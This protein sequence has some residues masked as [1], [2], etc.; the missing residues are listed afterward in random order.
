MLQDTRTIRAAHVHQQYRPDIDGLRTIAVMIVVLAHAGFTG[1]SG[2]FIGVDVFFVISGFVVTNSILGDLS[3]G[4]FSFKA[5]YARRASRLAPAL[6]LMLIATFCFSILFVFPEDTFKLAKNILA[7]ATMTSNIYLSKQTGYFDGRAADHPLLHTWSLSVEEQ[8]YLVLPVVLVLLRRRSRATLIGVL[9]AVTLGSLALAISIR[10]MD[11][12]GAYYFA[13]YR[14]FEFL[15]GVLLAIVEGKRQAKPHALFDTLLVAGLAIIA[16]GV[17]GASREAQFPGIGALLPCTAALLIIFAGR[18][19]R[20]TGPILANPVCVALGRISYPI[21]LWHWPIFFA[22]RRLSLTDPAAYVVAIFGAIALAAATHQLERRVQHAHWTA[23]RSLLGFVAVPLLGAGVLAG[24]GKLTDGFLFAYPAAIRSN[25]HWSGTALFDM[26]RARMCWSQVGIS[27]EATCTVGATSATNKAILWGDSH[28]YHLIHFF[29][30]LGKDRGM[31]IHDVAFTLCPPIEAMSAH[32]TDAAFEDTHRQ[33]VE[34]DKAVMTYALARQDVRTVI[35]SAA[36]QN[37]LN[38]GVG[39]DVKPTLHGFMPGQL[40]RE[41]GH[42]IE[43]LQ[44]AGKRVVMLDDVPMIPESMVNCAFYNGLLFPYPRRICEFDSKI[45]VDQHAPIAAMQARLQ[46]RF[47][48]LRII[49]TYDAPCTDGKCRLEFDGLPIYRYSD[50]HHLSL[51][52]SLKY[53]PEYRRK[54]PR[55]LEQLGL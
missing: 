37:Y 8:F 19:A 22:L 4:Q 53:Y 23:R 20:F 42:T 10:H 54:H 30:V 25:V 5:F 17:L 6:Y 28:A 18:R 36:W 48:D 31:A 3:R 7:V 12:P 34:H 35:M 50:Y 14:A 45:A 51:A 55:E 2:G 39:P 41:L 44:A 13:Q 49:H 21:Y 32:A 29:D 16:A 15:A 43:K 33:C 38:G 26:P 27:D 47:P 24:V 46:A 52:G 40:E 11:S 1:F 9:T